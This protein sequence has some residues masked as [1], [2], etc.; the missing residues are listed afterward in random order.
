MKLHLSTLWILSNSLRCSEAAHS[1]WLQA[2]IHQW[3]HIQS[4]YM[5]KLCSTK[6]P[7][8]LSCVQLDTKFFFTKLMN[9]T[10]Y[11]IWNLLWLC[12]VWLEWRIFFLCLILTRYLLHLPYSVIKL[13]INCNLTENTQIQI[14]IAWFDSFAFGIIIKYQNIT[15]K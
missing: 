12:W 13:V 7:K 9:K 8:G 2:L 4:G 5:H 6:E 14:L 11:L 10:F 3:V 1:P 15:V